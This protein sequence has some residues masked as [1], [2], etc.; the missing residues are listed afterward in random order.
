[1]RPDDRGLSSL[2]SFAGCKEIVLKLKRGTSVVTPLDADVAN[3]AF[4]ADG[5]SQTARIQRKLRTISS[6]S[7]RG[8]Y[9]ALRCP[10]LAAICG[11]NLNVQERAFSK[12]GIDSAPRQQV[13]DVL[14]TESKAEVEPDR[15][16]HNPG[17]KAMTFEQK[18]RDWSS[19][20]RMPAIL[21]KS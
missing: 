10:S 18:S 20:R 11:L 21:E 16:T 4:V 1:M 19:G 14:K 9:G 13:L 7:G 3:V 5:G 2:A 12:R 17:R 15:R 8:E 6:R